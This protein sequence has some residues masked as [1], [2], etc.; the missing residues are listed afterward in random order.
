MTSH[1]QKLLRL[2]LI[3]IYSQS[4]SPL[5]HSIF[6]NKSPKNMG[7]LE[8]SARG[9]HHITLRTTHYMSSNMIN[10]FLHLLSFLF[11]GIHP[12]SCWILSEFYFL[13]F[14]PK[15]QSLMAPN[16]WWET[17]VKTK[18]NAWS[19]AVISLVRELNTY[20]EPFASFNEL[21]QPV[22]HVNLSMP[23][24]G[25]TILYRVTR[26]TREQRKGHLPFIF[27]SI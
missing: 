27:S 24:V 7:S 10:F 9:N 21:T 14:Q 20:G 22:S 18:G 25:P 5:T 26:F 17:S 19:Y 1:V 4:C 11:L 3:Q 16:G 8:N 15:L 2:K 6:S 13:G 12:F 23:P